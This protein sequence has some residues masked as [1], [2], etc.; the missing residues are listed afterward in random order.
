MSKIWKHAKKTLLPIDVKGEILSARVLTSTLTISL[1]HL[2]LFFP[3]TG[4]PNDTSFHY[5]YWLEKHEI[6]PP[7]DPA[8]RTTIYTWLE[9]LGHWMLNWEVF[10]IFCPAHLYQLRWSN[11]NYSY[12][13]EHEVQ[14]YIY[15]HRFVTA[16]RP[17]ELTKAVLIWSLNSSVPQNTQCLSEASRK[18]DQESTKSRQV[19]NIKQ[20]KHSAS[21]KTPGWVWSR[22]EERTEPF[23]ARMRHR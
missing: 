3:P 8:L 22:A 17:L 6:W 1:W 15:I 16:T 4:A 7:E 20:V 21:E 23:A 13:N 12:Q 19:N 9:V 11:T 14:L 18:N 10:L 5:T 2:F